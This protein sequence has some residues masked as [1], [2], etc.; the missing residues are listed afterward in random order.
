LIIASWFGTGDALDAYLISLVI[1]TFVI[2]VIPVSFH[3][4]LLPTYVQV[5]DEEGRDK[6]EEIFSSIM[7]YCI[8]FLLLVTFILVFLG[9]FVLPLLA[10][11]FDSQKLALTRILYYCLLPIILIQGIITIGSAVLNAGRRFAL[12]AIVPA[13]TPLGIMIAL[14]ANGSNWGIYS[15]VVGTLMGLISQVFI[16][17]LGLKKQGVRL[18]PRLEKKNPHLR[19]VMKQYGFIL[20]SAF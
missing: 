13:L 14:I 4:A 6:A 3:Y 5:R 11:G 9:P 15:L 12:A 18:R 7:A 1:P 8:T 20:A 10:S 19:E 2:N 17:G 16:I